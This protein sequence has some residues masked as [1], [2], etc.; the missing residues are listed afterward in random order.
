MLVCL[1]VQRNHSIPVNC[2]VNSSGGA[3][4]SIM[5]LNCMCYSIIQ[6]RLDFLHVLVISCL[7]HAC[8]LGTCT[9]STSFHKDALGDAVIKE[10]EEH[11]D[12]VYAVEWSGVDPWVFASLSYD[13]RLVINHVPSKEKFR[14]LTI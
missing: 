13:G 2:F 9:F 6:S 8:S 7:F 4:F 5:L 10:F 1:I 11:E 12:S 14:I 3:R